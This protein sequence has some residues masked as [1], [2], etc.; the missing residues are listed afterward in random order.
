MLKSPAKTTDETKQKTNKILTKKTFRFMKKILLSL[1]A[2]AM[3]AACSKEETLVQQAPE[4][5]GFD[6][7]VDN[8]TRSVN[9]PSFSN[10]YLFSNFG[11]FGKVEGATLFDNVT[12]TGSAIKGTWSY[13]NT[14]YWIAGAKYSFGAVAPKT[15]NVNEVDTPVYTNASFTT[16][17]TEVDGVNKYTGT[18]ALTFANTGTTDLLYAW[19]EQDGKVSGNTTVG[20][21][22]RHVLSKV[23]FSFKNAYDASTATIKVHTI[24][25]ENAYASASASF[26]KDATNW[27]SQTGVLA[28]EFGNASDDESTVN[29]KEAAEVAYGYGKTYESLNER[30]LIPGVAKPLA[31]DANAGYKVTFKVD[32]LV[33]GTK[34]KT[35]DHVAYANFTPAAGFCYDIKTEINASN[36][37]PQHQ[38]EPIQFTVTAVNG[39]DESD[40]NKTM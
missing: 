28:L 20:F 15:I 29:A 14:Q 33:N 16:A 18:T 35:Y 36:I 38:Q 39:W 11:V 32:L 30:F 31:D 13:Q 6:T 22:F 12:V 37:D 26:T 8:A 2:V 25:V 24:K 21:S 1:A 7:F 5:I 17:V 3:L 40:Q 19:A 10:T 34:I 4:A 23:K 27:T 9:D